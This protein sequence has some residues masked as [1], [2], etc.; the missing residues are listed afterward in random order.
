MVGREL[1]VL[2][3]RG[4]TFADAAAALAAVE[5]GDVRPRIDSVYALD[6][7]ADAFTLLASR[8]ALGRVV[9]EI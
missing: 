7:A 2:G 6:Q 1:S 3:S 8:Q 4:S 9:I 5:R